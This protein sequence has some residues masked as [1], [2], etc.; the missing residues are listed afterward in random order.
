MNSH[1]FFKNKSLEFVIERSFKTQKA[2]EIVADLNV[3]RNYSITDYGGYVGVASNIS[4]YSQNILLNDND[5]YVDSSC[6]CGDFIDGNN[7]VCKHVVAAMILFVDACPFDN[8]LKKRND[9][10]T[11]MKEGM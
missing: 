11:M 2:R 9:L 6:T 5:E 4:N 1:D 10:L 8:V 3:N 7:H